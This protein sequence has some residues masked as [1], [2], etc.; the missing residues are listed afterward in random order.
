MVLGDCAGCPVR[1][2]NH[3]AGPAGKAAITRG[4]HFAAPRD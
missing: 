4:R 3:A 2:N 1:V